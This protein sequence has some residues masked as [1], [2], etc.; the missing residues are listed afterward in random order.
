MRMVYLGKYGM[1]GIRVALFL[2]LNGAVVSVL[3][4]GKSSL[5]QAFKKL[6]LAE[7]NLKKGLDLSQLHG[8]V[9][10][11]SASLELF[12]T[13]AT[14]AMAERAEPPR[15][16]KADWLT[17]G[18]RKVE[19]ELDAERAAYESWRGVRD[20]DEAHDNLR[21]RQDEIFDL[22][23]KLIWND[24]EAHLVHAN[25]YVP[26]AEQ[27]VNRFRFHELKDQA[28]EKSSALRQRIDFTRRNR[29]KELEAKRKELLEELDAEQK[30]E[31]AQEERT[32]ELVEEGIGA[33]VVLTVRSKPYHVVGRKNGAVAAA[34]QEARRE[35]ET[36][37]RKV[38]DALGLTFRD[39]P[40]ALSLSSVFVSNFSTLGASGVEKQLSAGIERAFGLAP[41]DMLK[42]QLT[43]ALASL[44]NRA[45]RPS[46]V[47]DLSR[48]PSTSDARSRRL[49]YLGKALSNDL[50][51]TESPVFMDLDEQGPRHVSVVGGSGSG[52][53]VAAGLILEGAAL[54][55]IP[56]LIFDPTR[57]WTGF[58]LPCMSELLLKGYEAFGL[59]R[60]W[61]R[62]FDVR[63]VEAG[64]DPTDVEL[65]RLLQH[66]GL[67]ILS[68]QDLTD[69]QEAEVA[70]SLLQRLY[71][72]IKQWEES[73][74]LKLLI[75][76]EEAHRYL[77]NPMLQPILELF[78]RTARS[79]GVGLLVVSQV[80]V[81]LPPAIRNNVATKI[82]MQSAYS[83]DLTRAG[84]VYGSEMQKLIPKFRQGM[85]VANYPD[86]GSVVV[87]FRPP[88]HSPTALPEGVAALYT[89]SKAVKAAVG[90]LLGRGTAGST[91]RAVTANDGRPNG[92]DNTAYM[93]NPFQAGM[94][95]PE[96]QRPNGQALGRSNGRPPPD[97]TQRDWR[98][99]AEGL[100]SDGTTWRSLS[101]A[102]TNEGTRP[103]SER[104]LRRF[105]QSRSRANFKLK[106]LD[107]EA[108]GPEAAERG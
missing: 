48:F 33:S 31:R 105:L 8:L 78:A 89:A 36:L 82:Q 34:A 38:S 88:L 86:Y 102:L 100:I 97:K 52:K 106:S 11:H 79:R 83:Q 60:G 67:T 69:D 37:K 95:P 45:E 9:A 35:S 77:Q 10:S 22:N 53:S 93:R 29:I 107:S 92:H 25:R 50:K 71:D 32:S 96:G 90:Q 85:G 13:N 2:D 76:L 70:A 41:R 44:M 73:K 98:D 108:I 80:A 14:R 39:A 55:G 24:Q 103:P 64:P 47:P 99:V 17:Y 30:K 26:S 58:A 63:I 27:Q 65:G 19:A 74:H 51:P 20:L 3:S 5:V 68:A 12:T 84:Q 7:P 42:K 72:E 61:A 104:T 54:H 18:L 46:Q 4:D 6:V 16:S 21:N 87:A 57:S 62:G 28:K 43:K 56:A 91:E 75:V 1:G 49:A 40:D 23:Q 81:D 66:T 94:E 59:E 101:E 15:R